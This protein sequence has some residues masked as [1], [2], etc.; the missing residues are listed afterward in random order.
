VDNNKYDT[1][2]FVPG[3]ISYSVHLLIS[4]NNNYQTYK[5]KTLYYHLHDKVLITVRITEQKYLS[6][7][8][9]QFIQLDT[10]RISDVYINY[11]HNS[12]H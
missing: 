11:G 2:D 7:W 12:G 8:Y 3:V 6:A 5:Y 1:V 10:K 9:S 4:T